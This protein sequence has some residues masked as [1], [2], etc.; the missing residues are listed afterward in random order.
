MTDRSIED[1]V[2]ER[3]R[4]RGLWARWK[5]WHRRELL[6]EAEIADAVRA[7]EIK[8][9]QRFGDTGFER[10]THGPFGLSP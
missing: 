5:A 10:G 2:P 9:Q 6:R 3:D 4:P 1:G 8:D 7:Q